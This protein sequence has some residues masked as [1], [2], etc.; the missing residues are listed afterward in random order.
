MKI[1]VTGGA[2]F[3]GSNLI[4]RLLDRGD[5]VTTIDNLDDYYD[6]E[7]KNNNIKRLSKYSEF[8]F[9]EGDIRNCD[10]LEVCFKSKLYDA[11]I[12]LAA[13][14]GVRYCDEHSKETVDVNY[15]GTLNI[16]NNIVRYRINKLV[17]ASTSSVYGDSSKI[18]FDE[19]SDADSPISMYGT[20]KRASELLIK[21]YCHSYNLNSWCL[22]LFTVHG[23]GQR[24]DLAIHKFANQI[25]HDLPVT[26]YGDGSSMR[27]YLYIEDAV[28]AFT[29]ALSRCSGYEEINIGESRTIVLSDL[30]KMIESRL[31][32]KAA[33]EHHD[34]P[35]G[36]PHKTF[37][38][39]SKAKRF[40]DFNPKT[41]FENGL[42]KFID[43]YLETVK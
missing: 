14:A 17:F 18:P 9:I 11:V 8:E 42:D 43:W 19:K 37:S 13:M 31:N 30:I 28:D 16:L 33:I 24:P 21:T 36:D 1:F 34:M 4:N 5:C 25:Y 39:I 38:N 26:I 22:R 41:N 32:K 29:T 10:L 3:I 12:H 27:D 23:P 20:T 15:V 6:V 7:I 40:L 2:G 35:K